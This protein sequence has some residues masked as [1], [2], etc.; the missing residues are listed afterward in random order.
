MHLAKYRLQR[1]AI[2]VWRWLAEAKLVF[3]GFFVILAAVLLGFVTWRNEESIRVAGY[4]L[5]LIGMI[6]ALRGL[7]GVRKHFGQ[8][9]LRQ[10][11]LKWVDRFPKWKRNVVIGVGTGH[12][13]M[14]GMKSRLEVWTPDDLE[15]PIEKRLDGIIKNLD[16]IRIE[17]KEHAQ[18]IDELKDCHVKHKN[19]V[20][21]ENRK[22]K[23]DIR[24]DLES[25]HTSDLITSL[26]GLVWLTV[27]ITLSTLAPEFSKWL[28]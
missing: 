4:A 5:Q 7:L 22:M 26:V 16:R 23:E 13:T 17:Q 25:L 20:A 11:F 3:M 14:T 12:M 9:L 15:K 1:W 19:E 6:F 28:H 8:P 24:S 27:G 2:E 21:E 10:L 18:L